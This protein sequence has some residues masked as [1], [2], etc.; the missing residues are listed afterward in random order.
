M[1]GNNTICA[2]EKYFP[3]ADKFVPERWLRSIKDK[4]YIHPYALL[5]FGHGRR[6]CVG[7]RFAEHV[8]YSFILQVNK[9]RC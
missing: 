2:N 3:E 5:P 7:Q 1:F 8:M 6:N 9:I 4:E